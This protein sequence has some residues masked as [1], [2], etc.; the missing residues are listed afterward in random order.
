VSSEPVRQT[1]SDLGAFDVRKQSPEQI[2]RIFARW[3]EQRKHLEAQ[4][5][6]R[7]T[8]PERLKPVP[9]VARVRGE[10]REP[11]VL[12]TPRGLGGPI[13]YS[14]SFEEV[15]ATREPT[16]AQR[17]WNPDALP[18]LARPHP[19]RRRSRM[20][21]FLAG[22]AS[23]FAMAAVAGGALWE[24]STGPTN[25]LQA[26]AK[27]ATD[28][29]PI[30]TPAGAVLP[31]I[32]SY[33][34]DIPM[35]EPFVAAAVALDET[36]WPLQQA[37]DLAL[38][39]SAPVAETAL[40]L[41]M[42]QLKPPVPVVQTA[43]KTAQPQ[44][45]PGEPAITHA[46]LPLVAG[47][48]SETVRAPVAAAGDARID[49][50]RPDALISR[51]N[52]Q[53]NYIFDSPDQMASSSSGPS[54]SAGSEADSGSGSAGSGGSE[55]SSGGDTGGSAGPRD[56][57]GRDSG[58]WG[59]RRGEPSDDGGGI[60]VG[61]SGVGFGGGES[62]SGDA[63]GE[64]SGDGDD[65]GRGKSGGHNNGSGDNGRGEAGDDDAGGGNSG[66]GKESGEGESGEGGSTGARIGEGIGGA[67]GS[68]LGGLGDALGGA[69]GGGKNSA[70]GDKGGGS[71]NDKGK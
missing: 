66:E 2:A 22:A 36:E 69:L 62:G 39:N 26:N 32:P 41:P 30:A 42:P 4:E 19:P 50:A 45:E 12:G 17:V 65:A 6:A 28:R 20:K 56:S 67:L 15:L 47:M 33:P 54:G 53:S 52:D 59:V 10:E 1:A 68:A 57:G 9:P 63:G 8:P 21:W 38:M 24:Q 3:N 5:S 71:S 14:T 40:L 61:E 60:V 29:S 49:D 25:R 70:N 44:A 51:G 43:S 55:D 46:D 48:T 11:S 18:K 31:A 23:V 58:I 16:L 7:S 13:H 34:M 37:V 64:D 35:A 27:P